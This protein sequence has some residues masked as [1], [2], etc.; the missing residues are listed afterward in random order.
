MLSFVG[1]ANTALI[2]MTRNSQLL[3]RVCPVAM[4]LQL[5]CVVTL[6][7]CLYMV[8]VCVVMLYNIP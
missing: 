6:G 8:K 1:E 3:L 5:Y 7:A 2:G 4:N